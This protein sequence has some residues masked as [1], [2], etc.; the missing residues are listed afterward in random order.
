MP[1]ASDGAEIRNSRNHA[2][3]ATSAPAAVHGKRGQTRNRLPVGSGERISR[4]LTGGDLV[5][6]VELVIDLRDV[7]PDL[8][9]DSAHVFVR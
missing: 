7:R 8:R 6:V 3:G 9:I 2:T 5:S 4:E 1:P